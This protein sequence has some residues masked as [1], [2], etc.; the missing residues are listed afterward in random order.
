[1]D[2]DALLLDAVHGLASLSLRQSAPAAPSWMLEALAETLARNALGYRAEP[3]PDESDPLAAES[4]GVKEPVALSAL[5]PTLI[6]RLPG[7]AAD[8][9]AAWEDS[10]A[11]GGDG[12]AF[13][14]ELG[15]RADTRGLAGVLADVVASRGAGTDVRSKRSAPELTLETP[16][17]L[18]WRRFALRAS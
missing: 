6:P 2:L 16:G 17:P 12:Q 5:F 8:L 11:S 7:G 1:R 10:A 18:A 14:R 3:V 9:R 4:G 13:L 15:V